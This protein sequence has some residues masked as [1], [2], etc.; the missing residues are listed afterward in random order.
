MGP[1]HVRPTTSD[2]TCTPSECMSKS[3]AKQA[4]FL[5]KQRNDA[6]DGRTCRSLCGCSR[7]SVNPSLTVGFTRSKPS[8]GPVFRFSSE[9]RLHCS[10]T[11]RSV[12]VGAA[13]AE[14]QMRMWGVSQQRCSDVYSNN[15]SQ[16]PMAPGDRDE[17][18]GKCFNRI[19]PHVFPCQ[20]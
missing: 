8:D 16:P 10:A 6:Y 9:S 1:G 11:A 3:E 18:E 12:I 4:D 19:M 7:G 17:S 13:V 5:S 2:S 14:L 15:H 20:E